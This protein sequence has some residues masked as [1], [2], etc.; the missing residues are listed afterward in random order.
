MATGDVN[1]VR[2]ALGGVGGAGFNSFAAGRRHYGAGRSAPNVG[3]TANTVGYGQR[4]ASAQNR[5]DALM[6][7]IQGGNF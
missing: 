6:R 1:P 5:K 2:V 7:R 4:D 3:K